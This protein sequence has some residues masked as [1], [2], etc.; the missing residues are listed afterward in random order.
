[1]HESDLFDMIEVMAEEISY[2]LE[3]ITDETQGKDFT[4]ANLK[5]L[6]EV[7][8]KLVHRRQEDRLDGRYRG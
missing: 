5:D 4:L 2:V 7:Y 1:M 6:M 3:G 8:Y